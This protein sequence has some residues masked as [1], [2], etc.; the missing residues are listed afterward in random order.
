MK[1]TTSMS[2]EDGK[3]KNA[4]YILQMGKAQLITQLLKIFTLLISINL[5]VS[6]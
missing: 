5:A 2:D 1:T 4:T 3:N 6:V